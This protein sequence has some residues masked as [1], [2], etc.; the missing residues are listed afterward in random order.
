M[1]R[2]GGGVSKRGDGGEDVETG[3]LLLHVNLYV[4]RGPHKQTKI[5]APAVPC[6]YVLY[7]R[8]NVFLF[9]SSHGCCSCCCCCC[10]YCRRDVGIP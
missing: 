5:P 2:G 10:C 6:V 3:L 9:P 1:K 4:A 8:R 7:Y